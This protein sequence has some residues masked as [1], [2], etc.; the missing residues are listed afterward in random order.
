M[1][2]GR[3][4]LSKPQ[5]AAQR[6]DVRPP[7]P[8]FAMNEFQ[9][10]L[11]RIVLSTPWLVD[12]LRVVRDVGPL[13]AYV[14][15]GVVRNAVWDCLDN[16]CRVAPVTDVDVVYFQLDVPSSDQWALR[17]HSAMPRYSWDV[18]NQADVHKWQSRQL[19][20]PI[21][22]YR[23][24]EAA[25]ASWPETATALAIRLQPSDAL[26]TVAP[27]GLRDLFEMQVRRSPD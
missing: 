9:A 2:A 1:S 10:K 19:G 24:L 26:A 21:S 27:Y 12:I 6:Q 8:F 14:G 4:I 16:A 18:T 11:E 23:S 25:V 7:T 17:L 13:D 3:R 22:P 20:R 15:A 5:A